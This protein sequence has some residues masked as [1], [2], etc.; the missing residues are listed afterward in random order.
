MKVR[1]S[2][3]TNSSSSS[4][5]VVG[6]HSE[7]Y[8]EQFKLKKEED[9]WYDESYETTKDTP[10][11]FDTSSSDRNYC[12]DIITLTESIPILLQTMTIPQIKQMF[13]DR[14]KSN[15]IAVDIDDVFFDYG[16]FYDG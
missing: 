6:V 14:A 7:K 8:A 11:G 13:I 5:I 1:T 10:K 15:G 2:F 12:G 9:H 16:G 3:V 4:F